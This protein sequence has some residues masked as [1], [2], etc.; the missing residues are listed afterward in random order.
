MTY[1]QRQLRK[2]R[3]HPGV[4]QQVGLALTL[5]FAAVCIGILA[6]V[7]WVLEVAA[8][9][10]DIKSLKPIDK[11]ASTVIYAADGSR[12]GYVQS[13]TIRVPIGWNKMPMVMRQGTVAIED[14]RFY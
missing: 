6:V 1:H 9:A 7:G 5:V 8:T 11:G 14:Q 3:R 2:R 13:D 10:P 4:K 12:L